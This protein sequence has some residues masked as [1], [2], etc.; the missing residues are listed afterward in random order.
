MKRIIVISFFAFVTLGQG[1]AQTSYN[2]NIDP[3]NFIN[4]ADIGE[5][6]E[7]NPYFPL[8]AGV[9]H[10]Y[11]GDDQTITVTVTED[12]K[13][14]M[15]VT[16]VV[17]R[18]VVEENGIV[19]E[20]TDDWYAQDKDGNV[21]YFGEDTTAFKDGKASTE[22]AWTAGVN[23][24]LPGVVMWAKPEVGTVY[25]QEYYAGHAEDMGKVLSL[26]D[27]A[28]TPAAS[29]DGTCLVTEDTTPLE[30]DA[31]E[32][33]YYAPGI[34]FIYEIK[35]KTG[36]TLELIEIVNGLEQ[37]T[38][39]DE[40][41]EME[42]AEANQSPNAIESFGK[43]SLQEAVTTAQTELDSSNTPFEVTLEKING[44]LLWILDF[45]DPAKQIS[46][47]AESGEVVGSS[48]LTR[49]PESDSVLTD[50]GTVGLDEV[51]E[52]AQSAYGSP[53]DVTEMA[54]EKDKTNGILTWR[55][56]IADKL[57]VI[58]ANTGAVLSKG[59]LN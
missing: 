41:E 47:S 42:G 40:A 17:V 21:W 39:D 58:D 11:K 22:G 24:A 10:I 14:I 55:V 20:D 26:T 49:V 7:P 6:V 56:D 15:G 28:S 9:T 36:E 57:V 46:V 50:Y 27:S 5:T 48:N 23:G 45:V 13:E 18:D 4:A 30:P 59:V 16:C 38:N 3:A 12:T 53:A 51:V 8:K 19:I 31:L 52:I 34:G 43:V 2:P 35:P 1:N 33:K 29:C 32:H 44:Q 54:L 37:E 25:R